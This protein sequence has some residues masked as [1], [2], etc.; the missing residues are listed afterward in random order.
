MKTTLDHAN[1]R[2]AKR[3]ARTE[4]KQAEHHDT[5]F[6]QAHT[7]TPTFTRRRE[8]RPSSYGVE[9]RSRSDWTTVRR[10]DDPHIEEGIIALNNLFEGNAESR[11]HFAEL[12]T[13][14]RVG[15]YSANDWAKVK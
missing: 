1:A 15:T 2:R 7:G 11:K 13:A 3:L 6:Y 12:E 10:F 9:D 5:E 4:A 8:E 14:S